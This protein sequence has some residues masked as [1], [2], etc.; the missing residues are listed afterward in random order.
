MREKNIPER[1]TPPN[2]RSKFVLSITD[3]DPRTIREVVDS[4]DEILWKTSIVE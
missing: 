4:E 3:D 1:Y 2:F